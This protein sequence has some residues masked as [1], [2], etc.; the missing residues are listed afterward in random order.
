[1]NLRNLLNNKTINAHPTFIKS[2]FRDVT[3]NNIDKIKFTEESL[4]SVSKQTGAQFL[5]DT[6]KKYFVNTSNLIFTDGTANIGSDCINIA[7]YFKKVNAIEI[8][9]INYDALTNNIKFLNVTN[10]DTYNDDSN[11]IISKLKQDIIYIDAPWGGREYKYKDK[12]NL[13]LGDIST[14]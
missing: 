3:D 6:I 8:S 7:K 4:Y 5:Y 10:I 11:K 2:V 14:I 9:K 13:Y 1:M 12:L